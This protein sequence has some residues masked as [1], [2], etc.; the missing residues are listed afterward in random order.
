MGGGL[1]GRGLRRPGRR[2]GAARAARARSTRRARSRVTPSPPPPGSRRCAAAPRRSTTGSASS[3][4]PSPRRWRERARPRPASRTSIQWAGSMFSVFFRDGAVRD[5][6][7]ARAQHVA[8]VRGVLPLDAQPGRPPAAERVRVVVRQRRAT[9]TPPSTACSARCPA[10]ARAAAEAFATIDVMSHA[11]PPH[12]RAPDAP[13]RGPQP[14]GRALRPARRLPPLR[15]RPADG[16]DWSADHLAD[17]DVTHVVASPLSGPRRRRRRS[18]PRTA[19]RV[20][21]DDRVIEAGNYFE[22]KTFGVGDGSAFASPRTGRKL[23]NPFTPVVGRALRARSPTRMLAAI[24]DARAAR[25]RPRGRHRL[26]PAAGLDRPQPARGPA[27]VARPAQAAS[28]RLASLTS[29]DLRRRRARR[30]STYSEPAAALLAQAPARRRAPDGPPIRVRRGRSRCSLL[31]GLRGVQLRTPTR[32]RRRPRSGD[33]K[34]YV[35]GDGSIE[36]SPPADRGAAGD[37]RGHDAR[38]VARGRGRGRRRQGRRRSTSGARGARR[39]SPRPPTCR[40]P[41][42]P[43]PP[44]GKPV[45]FM[46]IDYRERPRPRRGVPARPTRSPTPR[47]TDDGG[48][49]HPRPAG[50]GARHRRRRSSSTRRAGI[51]ARVAGQVT[52]AHPARP[53]RRRAGRARPRP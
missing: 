20:T 46:G 10:A 25:P 38:R 4:T 6:D 5:Y 24:A 23:V 37:A 12:R 35:S 43:A 27:A 52:A 18:R 16:P 36:S 8:G 15:A 14:R 30:R 1:P 53:R 19:C 7:D 13:R 17:H 31:A 44:P 40:R 33:R 29:P 50:Q 34:G 22:G 42:R 45:E 41:G 11:H 2:H 51:A 3:P 32:S 48:R 47:L 21:T 9:T 49:R 26:P 28:A 39:A